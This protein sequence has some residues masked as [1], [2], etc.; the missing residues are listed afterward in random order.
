M[1]RPIISKDFIKIMFSDVCKERRAVYLEAAQLFVFAGCFD[2]AA[3]ML[4]LIGDRRSPTALVPFI[5]V[6]ENK[7]IRKLI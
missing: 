4:K 1:K 3:F 7:H 6:L 5:Q 2:D